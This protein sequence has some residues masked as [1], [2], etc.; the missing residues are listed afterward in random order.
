M[1][2]G[3]GITA[4]YHRLLAHRS[5]KTNRFIQFVLAFA[6]SLAVQGGPIW[7]VAHHRALGVTDFLLFTNDCSDGTDAMLDA[8]APL[9]VVHQRN[10]PPQGKSLQWNA[11]H[12]AWA[13]SIRKEAD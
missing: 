2:R 4:G 13:H 7:W 3:L 1:F 5:F 6:G 10:V 12:Q 9:E 11:L 8:L